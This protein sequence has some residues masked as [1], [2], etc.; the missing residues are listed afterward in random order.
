MALCFSKTCSTFRFQIEILVCRIPKVTATADYG[1]IHASF[2]IALYRFYNVDIGYLAVM[3]VHAGSQ[4]LAFL[5]DNEAS[6]QWDPY[7]PF[8]SISTKISIRLC[9]EVYMD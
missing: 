5:T 2:G 1:H 7:G 4:K 6:S 9:T 8:T 3:E